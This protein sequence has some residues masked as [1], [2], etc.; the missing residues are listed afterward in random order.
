MDSRVQF[1]MS[2]LNKENELAMECLGLA[3]DSILINMRFLDVAIMKLPAK[4]QVGL[5]GVATDGMGFYYDAGYILSCYKKDPN[6]IARSYL[7]SMLHCIFNH[8][9][10]YDSYNTHL[11]DLAC[12]IAIENLIM[13]LE[14]EAVSLQDDDRRRSRLRGLRKNVKDLTAQKI[15]K[16]FLIFGLAEDD[17]REY[18][19]LFTRD[20]HIY[21][22]TPEKFEISSEEWKKISE[23]IKADLKTFSKGSGNNESLIKNLVEATKERVDYTDIIKR[24]VDMGEESSIND[25]EFDYIYYTYGMNVYKNVPLVEP[26]EYRDVKKIKDFAIVID[27]SASCQGKVV[28]SFLE[29]TYKIMKSTENFFNNINVH[30]IQCDNEVQSD[31]KITCEDDFNNF[32]KSGKL[33]GFGGTDFRPAFEYIDSLI[34]NKEF[35]NFKG[36]IYFTDGYGIYPEKA[37]DYDALFVFLGDN[38]SR[39]Q[40]PWWAIRL[41]IEAEDLN[42]GAH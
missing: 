9:F 2:E 40:P 42:E 41:E 17:D 25:E 22:R 29:K 27:T 8:S 26:L 20:L 37:P 31:D 28:K 19:E 16:H 5:K 7:H 12:D 3:R 35:D 32:I 6:I 1:P 24:F 15:Y 18:A 36:L 21:F 38:E 23:R 4:N 39:M 34:I 30:I 10:N 13:E 11:W 33:K 14:L